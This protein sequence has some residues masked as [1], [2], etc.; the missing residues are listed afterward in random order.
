MVLVLKNDKDVKKVKEALSTRQNQ[1]TFD[2]KK[3]CG[4]L[5]TDEDGLAIQKKLRDEWE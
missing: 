3:F 2:A 5:K 4:A 1:K